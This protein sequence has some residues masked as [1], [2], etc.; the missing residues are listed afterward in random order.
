MKK[1]L[2]LLFTVIFSLSALAGCGESKPEQEADGDKQ[3]DTGQ[4]TE[5]KVNEFGWEV[6]E[7]TIEINFYSGQDNP[8]K[9]NKYQAGLQKYILENFNVKLNNIVY[10][11]DQKEKVNLMLASGDYPEVITGLSESQAQQWVNQGKA[12]EIGQYMDQYGGNIKSQ[13]EPWFKSYFSQ[14]G[15]LYMLPKFWGMLPIPDFSAHI[16]NDWYTAMG[17]PKFETPEQYYDILKQMQAAHPKNAKGEKTYALSGIA[18]VTTNMVPTLAGMWGLQNGY[19]VSPEGDMTHWVNT[20]EG[21]ELTKFMNQIY[22]DG[23]LDPDTFVNKFDEWK[24]KFS[25]ERIMGHIGWWWQSWNAG[26]EVW[27]KTNKDL[28][29]DQR[30]VQVGLKA[31]G[32]EKAY[33][34][35]KNARG[36]TFTIITDK[37]KHPEDIVKWMNFSITDMGTRLIGWGAPN[38][39][40][41]VWKFE[42]GKWSW[43]EEAKQAIINATWNYEKTDMLG[44]VYLMLVEGQGTMKDDGK[45]TLWFDQNFNNEAKWKKI[46]NDNLK[47]TIYD[48]S[49]G[50]IT[51]P[52][53][54]PLLITKQQIDDQLETLWAKTVMSKTEEEMTKNFN[55]MKDKLNSAGLHDIEKYRSDVY[56][57]RMKNWK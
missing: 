16:R 5:K 24:A 45:S 34:S 21:L 17:S 30:Y 11:V 22:R 28:K 8:D 38:Q 26:H 48:N 32:A 7:K 31:A 51:I 35:P 39:P 12:V 54:D 2:M 3:S 1:S 6:P 14:D 33:L 27:Q 47:D 57:D 43:V 37:A 46:M 13:L 19:K 23:L 29:E 36:G 18:P 53:N 42:N 52:A 41:S 49:M 4:K 20:Q 50:S 10:D 9:V 15:K 40:D 56:K 55:D 44:Q 25:S